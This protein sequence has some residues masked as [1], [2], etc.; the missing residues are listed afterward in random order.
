M[1]HELTLEEVSVLG[2]SNNAITTVT[3]YAGGRAG[4]PAGKV[5]YHN[6]K[7]IADYGSL[8][9]AEAVEMRIPASKL[10]AFAKKYFSLFG[11][12]G[13]RHD[14]QDAGGEYRSVLGL[15]GGQDSPYFEAVRSAAA[16]SPMSLIAGVGDEPDTLGAKAVLVYDSDKFPFYP[17]ELYHQFHNDFAG[18]P[19]G[20][21]Y[22][23]LADSLEAAGVLKSTGCPEPP[24][25]ASMFDF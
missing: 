8:G 24:K 3:G 16:A 18:A 14:P 6:R 13:Y 9:H 19:Y 23:K 5:C 22:N 1:Q 15:K 4:A 12:R 11:Q 10:P 17:A 25:Q 20:A 2:R 7:N 21:A